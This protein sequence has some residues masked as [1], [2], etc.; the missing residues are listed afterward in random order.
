M[1]REGEEREYI[2]TVVFVRT[3]AL[4]PRRL[5]FLSDVAS[6]S[7]GGSLKTLSFLNVSGS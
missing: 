5:F 1:K 4:Q 3:Q 2:V 7:H 6:A